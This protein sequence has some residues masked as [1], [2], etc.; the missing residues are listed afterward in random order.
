MKVYFIEYE[1][2]DWDSDRVYYG[3]DSIHQSL[4]DAK[5]YVDRINEELSKKGKKF[6]PMRY[7]QIRECE[8]GETLPSILEGFGKELVSW[9]VSL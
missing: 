5:A 7:S 3:I 1:V 6:L 8:F 4:D 2:V 9:L